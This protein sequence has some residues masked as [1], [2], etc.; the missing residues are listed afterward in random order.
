MLRSGLAGGLRREAEAERYRRGHKGQ[1]TN[2]R[3]NERISETLREGAQSGSPRGDCLG[4]HHARG[5]RGRAILYPPQVIEKPDH[6]LTH[7]ER[8]AAQNSDSERSGTLIVRVEWGRIS[9]ESYR[10][11]LR[12]ESHSVFSISLFRRPKLRSIK[13]PQ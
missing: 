12:V 13:R 2:S 8:L 9:E 6:T 3:I 1:R 10:Q 7:M 11:P 5:R 4:M